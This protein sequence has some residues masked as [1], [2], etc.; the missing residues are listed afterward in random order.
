MKGSL[1]FPPISKPW[2]A[3]MHPWK[4]RAGASFSLDL[5]S[6][7]N[8]QVFD[9]RL[10]QGADSQAQLLLNRDKHLLLCK[11]IKRSPMD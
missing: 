6:R 9:V 5:Q 11:T 2:G 1:I 3:V 10:D 4:V 7:N 8:Y